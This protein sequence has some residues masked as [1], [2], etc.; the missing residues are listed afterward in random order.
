MGTS[1]NSQHRL[2]LIKIGLN[3]QAHISL[4]LL[5]WNFKKANWQKFG[6]YVEEVVNRIPKNSKSIDCFASLLL[7]AAKKNIPKGYRKFY[8]T[9]WDEQSK[10]LFAEYKQ[11]LNAEVRKSLLALL[12]MAKKQ[13]WKLSKIIPHPILLQYVKSSIGNRNFQVL[14]GNQ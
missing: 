6:K 12:D 5:R 3:L 1:P 8:I 9:G 13:K 2:I 14:L 4:P 10:N 7:K 11:N